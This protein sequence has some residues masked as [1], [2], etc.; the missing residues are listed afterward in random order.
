MKAVPITLRS[1]FG[2]VTLPRRMAMLCIATGVL[3]ACGG[4]TNVAALPGTGGTGITALGPVVGFGSVIVNG[5]R[6]DDTNARVMIDG[7]NLWPS[8][9]RLGMVANVTGTKSDAVVTASS[10]VTATGTANTI[11]VWSIAQGQL[12]SLVSP[13]R[14]NVAGMEM[15]TDLGTVLE[16]AMSVNDLSTQSIVKVWGLPI[17]T[18]FS[19]WSVTRLQVLTSTNNTISTGKIVMDGTTPTLHGWVLK[20]SPISL[21]DGMLVRVVGNL[22]ASSTPN[23]LS[24]SKV[25]LLSG[26]ASGYAEL[27]G[28]VS[29][30]STSAVNTFAKV[31]RL[32]M[33]AIEVDTS[34]ASVSPSGVSLTNGSR[35][36]VKGTWSAGVLIATKVE[37][38]SAQQLQEVEIEGEILQFTSL[39]SFVVRGQRCDASALTKIENGNL[40]SLAVGKRVELYGIKIGD[41]VKVTE[42]E[43]K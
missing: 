7:E 14:F 33:G 1:G 13:N 22:S 9:L 8:N 15:I 26:A 40:S 20:N 10:V 16:G 31:I 42:L 28:V 29:S 38:K 11:E 23:T 17:T 36:E 34:K 6:F 19:Q 30:V 24:I 41:I 25:S 35:I 27:Q 43:L 21:K 12:S 5:T 18:D 39:A 32:T 37:I 3:A 4:G 2:A